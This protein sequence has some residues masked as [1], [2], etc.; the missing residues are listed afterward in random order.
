MSWANHKKMKYYIHGTT[1]HVH[2]FVSQVTNIELWAQVSIIIDYNRSYSS[3]DITFIFFKGKRV[4]T[5]PTGFNAFEF[6]E[7]QSKC[8]QILKT[9]ENTIKHNMITS[10]S[11][12]K[13][14]IRNNKLHKHV[15]TMFKDS[16][17]S[18]WIFIHKKA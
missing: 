4:A 17:T 18:N 14:N 11:K 15:T 13:V 3:L 6:W 10:I 2:L 1:Q 5:F 12:K 9:F 16:L 8:L 7:V